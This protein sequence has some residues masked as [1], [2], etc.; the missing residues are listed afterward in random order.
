MNLYILSY[1]DGHYPEDDCILGVYDS[2]EKAKEAREKI[3]SEFPAKYYKAR[4]WSYKII[5]HT[6]NGEPTWY[7]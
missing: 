7:F 1:S 6:L 5:E 2:E 4:R 3:V